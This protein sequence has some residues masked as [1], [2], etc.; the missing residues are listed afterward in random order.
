MAG[1][2]N[3]NY[4]SPFFGVS[5]TLHPGFTWNARYN[6]YRYREG[7]PS[8]APFCTTAGPTPA[9]PS[10]VVPC[11][12]PTLAGLQTG[13]TLSNAGETAAREFH[14]NVLT[15]GFHYEF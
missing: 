13:L 4:Q 14:A 1:S 11:N 12:S 2:L 15:L 6:Y 5:W 3:S 8:G 9:V 7:G 10:T